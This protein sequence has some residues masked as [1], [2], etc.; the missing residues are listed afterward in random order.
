MTTEE[1]DY[2]IINEPTPNSD[3]HIQFK[4]GNC[5]YFKYDYFDDSKVWVVAPLNLFQIAP[6]DWMGY[7]EPTGKITI[8]SKIEKS[9]VTGISFRTFL[10]CDSLQ[11]I[12]IPNSVTEISLWAFSGCCSLQSI[13]VANN[14]PKYDS[15]NN[16]NA[17]IETA[18]NKLIVGCK[19]TIIPDSVMAI[20]VLAFSGC[21]SLPS[22]VIPDSVTEVGEKTFVGCSNLH[23]IVISNSVTKIGR[24]TFEGCSSLRTIVIPDSVTEIERS[25]FEGCSSLQTI[26]IPDSVTE[27]G[28]CAFKGCNRLHSITISDSVSEIGLAAFRGCRSLRSIKIKNPKLLECTGIHFRKVKIITD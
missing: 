17:I 15:R 13:I 20:E 16:C 24:S 26:V 2:I 5:L 28:E 11:T 21:N 4:D 10:G 14:N 6:T 7:P 22:I 3:F 12:I 19:S 23:T 25:T 1:L 8:P 18:S 9:Q 27:I